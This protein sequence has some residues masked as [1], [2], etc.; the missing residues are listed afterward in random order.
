MENRIAP[1]RLSGP[2]F[3]FTLV[4]L[5]VVIAIIGALAAI[6]TPMIGIAR[7]RA[8]SESCKQQ[9]LE[10]TLSLESYQGQFGDYPPSSIED[11]YGVGGNSLDSGIESV[12]AHLS[13]RR[14]PGENAWDIQLLLEGL[15]PEVPRTFLARLVVETGHPREPLLEAPI[16]G[17]HLEGGRLGG[18]DR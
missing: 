1:R 12:V 8:A 17:F 11:H 3:G 9:I 6:A 5:L 13:T 4:E 2:F 18:E 7:R 15:A 14:V 10:L 16:H